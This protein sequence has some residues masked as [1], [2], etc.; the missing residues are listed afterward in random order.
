MTSSDEIA[1]AWYET[2]DRFATMHGVPCKGVPYEALDREVQGL[3]KAT[4]NYLL[5]QRI[6][7]KG[8][9]SEG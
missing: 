2:Y 8:V 4:V 3:H 9:R 6:I 7:Q 1:K 5:G